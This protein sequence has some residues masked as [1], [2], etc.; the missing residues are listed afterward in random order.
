VL[1]FAD[2]TEADSAQMVATAATL[3]WHVEIHYIDQEPY[4]ANVARF[5]YSVTQTPTLT[6]IWYESPFEHNA[7]TN[8]VGVHSAG[9]IVAQVNATRVS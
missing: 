6:V 9:E 5:L 2:S 7:F 8:I 4:W 3:P 1:L